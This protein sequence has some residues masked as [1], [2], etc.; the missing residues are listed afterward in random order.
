MNTGVKIIERFGPSPLVPG[1]FEFIAAECILS[2]PD[3]V[4]VESMMS[5]PKHV[6]ITSRNDGPLIV[7]CEAR[8]E[9]KNITFLPNNKGPV[10]IIVFGF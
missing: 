1:K 5:N 8:I 10:S 4:C 2:N 3:R 7:Q 6:I 9:G